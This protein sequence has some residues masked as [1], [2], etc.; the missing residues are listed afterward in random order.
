M[1]AMNVILMDITGS[2]GVAAA[3]IIL[4]AQTILSYAYAGYVQGISPVMWF[5]HGGADHEGLKKA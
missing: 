3:A 1:I 4:S 5:R 2:D